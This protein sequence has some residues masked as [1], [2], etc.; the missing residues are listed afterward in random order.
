MADGSTTSGSGGVVLGEP[1]A[2]AQAPTA[3][4]GHG[5]EQ[6][7]RVRVLRRGEERVHVGL[8]DDLAVVHDG[9]RV[10]EVRDDAHVVRDEHD[11]GAEL[12]GET[13]QELEDLGLHGDVEG[14]RRLV[15]DDQARVERERLRDDD[16]LLLAAGELVRVVV[17]AVLGVGD[18]DPAQHV[19]RLGPGVGAGDRQVRPQPLG[20]LPADRVDG[21]EDR[22]RLLEDHRGVPAAH[23]AQLVAAQRDD[24]VR[25]R[26]VL[27]RQQ[28][29]TAGE[30]GLGQQAED[31]SCGHGLARPRLA[32][33]GEH[34]AGP[35]LQRD[36]LDGPDGAGVGGE[37][38]VQVL[39]VDDVPGA[40]CVLGGGHDRS[41]SSMGAVNSSSDV[42]SSR[43]RP[44][45]PSAPAR[46]DAAGDDGHGTDLRPP[47][48]RPRGAC[49][50]AGRR[51]R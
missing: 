36:A 2:V 7:A 4:A 50:G 31:R 38:D 48:A 49:A 18:A 40:G 47:P 46:Q 43:S 42:P 11:R 37:R 35:D 30:G 15:G 17:D 51:G 20:D 22:R 5:V 16:A 44:P 1:D 41:S 33:D 45:M 3:D 34:L 19:D 21:V 39:D 13:A 10:G 27:A 8:L 24:V 23:V 14:G 25:R 32:D 9:D 28:H 29:G 12:L 26:A 6:R